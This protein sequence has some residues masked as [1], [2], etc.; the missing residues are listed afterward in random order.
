MRRKNEK[1]IQHFG[2]QNV[3]WG[4][5]LVNV[6]MK[7]IITGWAES[8]SLNCGHKRAYC[9]YPRRYMSMENHGE[10]ISTGRIYD[11]STRALWQSYQQLSS[12]RA[13]E[14]AKEIRNFTL[15]RLH[16]SRVFWHAVKSYYMGLT[17]SSPF[18]RKI[19]IAIK[20]PSPPAGFEPVNLGSNGEDA[21]N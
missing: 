12:S 1:C 16:T 13:G 17:A 18:R 2:L 11:S 20:N 15:R 4:D 14:L 5:Y 19:F 21:N 8:T 10:I 6:G 7:M 9:S 3:K